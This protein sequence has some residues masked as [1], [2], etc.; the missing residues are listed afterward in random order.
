MSPKKH[1]GLLY[2]K[3]ETFAHQKKAHPELV[4]VE[5]DE[6]VE[7]QKRCNLLEQDLHAVEIMLRRVHANLGLL[8]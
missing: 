7:F 8:T 3:K 4:D 6:Q 5:D 2:P 1:F